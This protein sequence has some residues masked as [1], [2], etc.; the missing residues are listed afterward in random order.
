MEVSE[1]D[2]PSAASMPQS[3]GLHGF[4]GPV[5]P[6]GLCQTFLTTETLKSMNLKL[7]ASMWDS[8]GGSRVPRSKS[9]SSFSRSDW[10]AFSGG[11]RYFRVRGQTSLRGSLNRRGPLLGVEGPPGANEGTLVNDGS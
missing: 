3:F 9:S 5:G 4:T 6:R 7:S 8:T 11:G 1:S 2:T 10:V